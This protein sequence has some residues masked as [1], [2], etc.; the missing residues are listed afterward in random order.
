[1]RGPINGVPMRC[2][3]GDVQSHVMPTRT[4]ERTDIGTDSTTDLQTPWISSRLR[5]RTQ[6]CDNLLDPPGVSQNHAGIIPE[7]PIGFPVR[8]A[9]DCPAQRSSRPVRLVGT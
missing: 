9:P 5:E 1:M 8:F 3:T 6:S 7:S 4:S 2:V